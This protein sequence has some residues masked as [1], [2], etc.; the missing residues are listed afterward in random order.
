[1]FLNETVYGLEALPSAVVLDPEGKVSYSLGGY[2]L[3]SYREE[4]RDA[5]LQA[6]GN[7]PEGEDLQVA[8]AAKPEAEAASDPK[9]A[10]AAC[11]LPRS[12]YC[13]LSAE[14]EGGETDPAVMA[15]RLSLC[16]GDAAEAERMIR[17]IGAAQFRTGELRF[18]LAH[19]ML[20]KGRGMAA[21]GA[22]AS[23]ADG[24]PD[25]SWGNWGLG[26]VALAEGRTE[27]ALA[28]MERGVRSGTGNAE[29][30]TAGLTEPLS[31][32]HHP[33]VPPPETSHTLPA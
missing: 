13:L 6:M 8:S 15:L 26:L 33:S 31:R 30:E 23:I 11:A 29:A 12:R 3:F 25:E 21:R 19:L 28:H 24:H 2:P 4:L 18:A 22:F 10:R 7:A 16:R 14:R 32:I 5:F 9:P 1:L 20:L 17:G 27:E